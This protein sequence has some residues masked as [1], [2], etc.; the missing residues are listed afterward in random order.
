MRTCPHCD[1]DLASGKEHG[2]QPMRAKSGRDSEGSYPSEQNG[3]EDSD[4]HDA[5]PST[6]DERA[7]LID[8]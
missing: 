7:K 3:N 4:Y 8:D 2:K 6:S 1:G 5:R